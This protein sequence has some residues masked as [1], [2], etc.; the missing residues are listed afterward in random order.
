MEL[1]PS[2]IRGR[3]QEQKYMDTRF[4]SAV[5]VAIILPTIGVP[6]KLYNYAVD[7]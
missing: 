7:F 5:V 2:L 1:K 6:F 4:T 3:S